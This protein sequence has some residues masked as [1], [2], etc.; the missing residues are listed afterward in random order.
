MLV[1]A[2]RLPSEYVACRKLAAEEGMTLSEAERELMGITHAD[3]G[4]FLLG[5]WGLPPAIVDAVG[6]HL[7]AQSGAEL[8]APAAVHVA[9]ALITEQEEAD[10]APASVVAYADPEAKATAGLDMQF[11]ERIGKID[12]LSRWR[13][14]AIEMCESAG[15]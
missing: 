11:L 1:L 2:T 7:E 13:G 15:A 3:I 10:G 6:G 4:A 14:W 8:D 9:N 5:M 12:Q